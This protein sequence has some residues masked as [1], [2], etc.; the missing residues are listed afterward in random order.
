MLILLKQDFLN[1]A[2]SII[3]QTKVQMMTGRNCR[4]ICC[5]II[6][7]SLGGVAMAVWRIKNAK[8]GSLMEQAMRSRQ[9]VDT[10]C[11]Y[12]IPMTQEAVDLIEEN[13]DKPMAVF[14]DYDVDG[15]CG[16]LIL[17]TALEKTG[18]HVTVHLPTR[19]EGYGIKPMHVQRLH[20][21]GIKTIITV[22]TGITAFDAVKVAKDKGMNIIITDHHEPQTNIPDCI[23]VNPKLSKDGFKDYSGAGV[24]YILAKAIL[25]SKDICMDEDLISLAS[26]ATV[27]DVVPLVGPNFEIARKGLLQMR[28]KPS[29]G[30]QALIKVAGINHLTGY[31]FGW[32]LGPRIN[33]AGRIKDPMIAYELLET[34]DEETASELAKKLDAMNKDR[35]AILD[36]AVRECMA[37]YDES[38]FPVLTC[39]QPCG[40][41]G[42]AAGRIASKIR[43]PTIVGRKEN[44]KIIA[45]GRSVGEFSI[46]NALQEAHT[47][48]DIPIVFGGHKKACGLEIESEQLRNLQIALNEIAE[49]KLTPEDITEWVDIDGLIEHIPSI[50]EVE[51]LDELEPFGEENPEPV[52]ALS[53]KIDWVRQGDNWQLASI[54]G[55]KFFSDPNTQLVQGQNIHT[56]VSLYINEYNGNKE[57]MARVKD[58]KEKITTR[59]KLIQSYKK[60]REGQEIR[61]TEETIFKELGFSK[62]GK[63][64]KSNLINSETFRTYGAL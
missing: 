46:L 55:I 43:R 5:I 13:L 44:D 19:E 61:E 1:V 8:P 23:I 47:K 59:S 26:L 58:I 28:K 42:L 40:I 14:G 56:A 21:Q 45:S 32:Q 36:K 16:A 10:Y 31:S 63:T 33:V 4:S 18:A 52:Y 50:E 51:E 12:E 20:T 62:T 41:V 39:D 34:K 17:K 37:K 6:G 3:R 27:A 15:I 30:L 24:A 54:N 35:Q 11:T 48:Y 22:D 53:G 49:E 9:P 57:V 60:W 64:T 7:E 29:I 38:T 2:F 25:E